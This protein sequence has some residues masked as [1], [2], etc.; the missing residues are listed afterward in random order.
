MMIEKQYIDIFKEYRQTIDSN[1][2]PI[3]NT[4]RDKA[5]SAFEK[6][7]FPN[8]SFEDY[9]YIDISA[10]F[11][12]DFGL[13]LN[14]VPMKGNPY[15]AFGC[16]VPNM[17]T[18]L[19]YNLND[20]PHK[21]FTP[22]MDYPKGVFVGSLKDFALEHEAICA[23]YYAQIAKVDESAIISFN[24]MFAQDGFVIYVPKN[25]IVEKPIQLINILK[26]N[27]D[28]LVNRRVLIIA[29]EN[30]Q[31]RLLSCD[32]TVDTRNFLVTQVNEIYAGKNAIVDFYDMEENSDR[33][34]RLTSTHIKQEDSSNVLFNN[35]ALTSGKT[36]NNYHVELAGEHAE[37][38][39]CGMVIGDGKHY[40]DNFVYMDHAVPNCMSTQ[41]F[42]YVLQ[43]E[44]TGSFCGRILVRP[45]AQKTL[46]YQSNN[47][48]CAS[49]DAKMYSKPQ[50]EIYA[51]DVKCSHG[52]TTGQLDEEALLYLRSRGIVETDARFMLM[53][54]FVAEVLNH[55]R[56]DEL[57][58][59]L[60][61]LVE[62]RFKGEKAR[63][64]DC[65]ICK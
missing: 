47:N 46:A 42:K 60:L 15:F 63:C 62:K 29:E 10:E 6:Q 54:A 31:V 34:T 40:I 43:E 14:R 65:Q 38:Y 3:L 24:T 9:R 48:L 1:S 55:V 32:H 8:K 19:Y 4:Q 56:I 5:L 11:V 59:R 20:L 27:L 23:K 61:D 64:G 33:V 50:L 51:D 28:Y 49:P 41:L 45:D 35:I 2:A 16:Q 36:R 25:T 57:K 37:A 21:E 52:L 18:H 30:S 39:V 22:K 58:E 13:N 7:G 44:S 26:S 17:C 12:P 53:Q